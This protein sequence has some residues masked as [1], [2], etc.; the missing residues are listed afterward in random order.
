[1]L[2]PKLEEKLRHARLA[3]DGAAIENVIERCRLYLVLLAEYRDEL[4]TLPETLDLN[5]RSKSSIGLGVDEIRK[6]VR[7]AIEQTTRERNWAERLLLSF[8]AVSGYGAVQTFNKQKYR[9]RDDW[10]LCAGGVGYG[11]GAGGQRMPVRE[12][13]ETASLLR[14]REHIAG[15]AAVAEA[16]PRTSFG[17]SRS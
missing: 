15:N 8:T 7:A 10:Q 12:A 13:V 9:G 17:H 5:P 14:C 16:S 2:R 3:L 4:Y 11:D 6:E 1:M